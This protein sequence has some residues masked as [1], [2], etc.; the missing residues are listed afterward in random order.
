MTPTPTPVET[1]LGDRLYFRDELLR[2]RE[3]M[4]Q[5]SFWA[6]PLKA[7]EAMKGLLYVWVTTTNADSSDEVLMSATT[8]EY[9]RR[10]AHALTNQF[11]P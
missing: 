8:N 11:T 7:G 3:Y 4:G 2:F 1:Q 6:D 5:K 9:D 10:L